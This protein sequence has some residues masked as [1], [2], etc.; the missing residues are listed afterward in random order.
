MQEVILE[1]L[2]LEELQAHRCVPMERDTYRRACAR[3]YKQAHTSAHKR[4]HA[5]RYTRTH[6]QMHTNAH[7]ETH[8]YHTHVHCVNNQTCLY[9]VCVCARAC[10][11][12]T[13]YPTIRSTRLNPVCTCICVWVYMCVYACMYDCMLVCV[14]VFVFVDIRWRVRLSLAFWCSRRRTLARRFSKRFGC[15]RESC[16][17]CSRIQMNLK[18]WNSLRSWQHTWNEVAVGYY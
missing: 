14:R 16:W 9:R 13:M 1:K 18:V 5:R 6:T 11:R 7:T 15:A 2:P 4:A 17:I 12:P 10:A 8:T 3:E